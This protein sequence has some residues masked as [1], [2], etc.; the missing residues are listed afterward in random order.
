[1][2]TNQKGDVT[3]L[4]V[5]AFLISKG[6]KISKPISNNLRYDLIADFRGKLL[7]IQCK[8]STY[9]THSNKRA[10]TFNTCSSH[11]NTKG[12]VRIPYSKYDIDYIATVWNGH[13]YM[14][15]VEETGS[16]QF[17]LRLEKPKN[18]QI[19]KIHFIENYSLDNLIKQL[20]KENYD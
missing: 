19:K 9:E 13:C 14:I 6:F 17:M 1:M 10:I 3:E 15:P 2:T 20:K 8:S 5:S 16:S 4:L 18:N 12:Q 11:I 7:R